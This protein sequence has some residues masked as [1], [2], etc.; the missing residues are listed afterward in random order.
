MSCCCVRVDLE[1]VVL[2]KGL[3]AEVSVETEELLVSR[4]GDERMS[5][6]AMPWR[7]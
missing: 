7:K 3:I 5:G 6:L 4:E 1:E 2:K